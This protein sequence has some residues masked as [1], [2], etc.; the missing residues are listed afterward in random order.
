MRALKLWILV[1]IALGAPSVAFAHT[2]VGHVAGFAHGF[3][4]PLSGP[5]HLLAMLSV[6]MLAYQM[7]GRAVWLLP[8]SFVAVMAAGGV[9]GMAGMMLPAVETGIAL[10]VIALG[11][12]LASG[13]K[14]PVPLAVTFVG[15]F[16]LFHGYAHGTEM[17]QTVSGYAYGFGFI[18]ATALIHLAGITLG[19][20][21]GRLGALLKRPV[22]PFAG[23]LISLFG[24]ALLSATA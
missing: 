14:L 19:A 7:G 9:L 4:H 17:P 2:G 18:G 22:M 11:A 12:A 20:A 23:G 1:I 13:L 8:P 15:V 6:G 24:I 5:D 10:S 3:V 16:A 21:F